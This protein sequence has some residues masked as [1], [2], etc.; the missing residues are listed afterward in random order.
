MCV[1]YK[2]TEWPHDLRNNSSGA[3]QEAVFLEALFAWGFRKK[4]TRS[5]VEVLFSLTCEKWEK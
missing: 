4:S 5:L 2:T 1:A 3:L